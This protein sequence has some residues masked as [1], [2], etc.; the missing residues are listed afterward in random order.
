MDIGLQEME[1]KRSLNGVNQR[2]RKKIHKK[3]FSATAIL[4]P[5]WEKKFYLRPLLSITFPQG[6]GKY[7]KFGDWTLGSGGIKTVKRSGKHQYQ[8]NPAQYGKIIPKTNIFLR[9]DFT[10]L[11]V[12]FQIWHHIFSLLFPQGYRISKNIG[13]PTWAYMSKVS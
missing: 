6:F 4:H 13:Q 10:P 2:R 9:G 11:L 12:K 5:L 3:N 7:K 8:K 1:A